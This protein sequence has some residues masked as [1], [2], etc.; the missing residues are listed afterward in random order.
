LRVCYVDGGRLVCHDEEDFLWYFSAH[1]PEPCLRTSDG[2]PVS[3]FREPAA[4][5]RLLAAEEYAGKVRALASRIDELEKYVA[6]L[7]GR[8]VMRTEWGQELRGARRLR[9]IAHER[10]EARAEADAL[11]SE[12]E[13]AQHERGDWKDLYSDAVARCEQLKRERD[14]PWVRL[15]DETAEAWARS[16][17]RTI[18]PGLD[19]QTIRD[20]RYTDVLANM[21]RYLRD[22]EL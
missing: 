16:L 6:E 3:G 1:N 10:D 12:L 13:E 8:P 11:R 5:D 15:D 4:A 14:E 18:H 9:E 2:R 17:H 22:G 19:D 7:E 21:L 20:H